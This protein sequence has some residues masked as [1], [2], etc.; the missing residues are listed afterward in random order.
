MAIAAVKLTAKD[1][2]WLICGPVHLALWSR[3]DVANT[4]SEALP[5]WLSA[6]EEAAQVHPEKPL[7]AAPTQVLLLLPPP[8][9][10]QGMQEDAPGE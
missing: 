6:L 8:L 7:R 1:W 9:G 3:T 5:T 2:K 10:G 4:A